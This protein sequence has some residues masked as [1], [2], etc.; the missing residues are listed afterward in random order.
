MENLRKLYLNNNNFEAQA[1]KNIKNLTLLKF[2][3]IRNNKLGDSSVEHIS[4][5]KNLS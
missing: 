2:L 5:L 4:E 3:D 1:L